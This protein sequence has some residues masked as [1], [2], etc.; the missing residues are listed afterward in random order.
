MR[1]RQILP[2]D[3]TAV[4]LPSDVFWTI[5]KETAQPFIRLGVSMADVVHIAGQVISS[6][7]NYD[8]ATSSGGFEH[9]SDSYK[10]VHHLQVMREYLEHELKVVNPELLYDREQFDRL[11]FSLVDCIANIRALLCEYVNV[12]IGSIPPKLRLERYLGPEHDLVFTYETP[13]PTLRPHEN[14]DTDRNAAPSG[15][16]DR[17]V[18]SRYGF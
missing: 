15:P 2:Q 3:R 5:V 12:A 1:A 8:V 4:I 9:R 10:G 14:P 7:D 16:A 18:P 11:V 13:Q 6:Q 17:E